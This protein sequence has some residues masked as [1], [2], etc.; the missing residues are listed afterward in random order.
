MSMCNCNCSCPCN[1]GAVIASA[2][3]GIVAAFLQIAGVIT[4]SLIFPVVVLGIAV[5][6]LGILAATSAICPCEE[7]RCRCSALNT[8]LAGILGSVLFSAVL[9]AVGIVATSVLSAILVGLVVFFGT[10]TLTATACYVR[11]QADCGN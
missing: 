4:V 8:V 11:T 7:G 6:Y 9:L 2:I 3:L 1:I 5:V 10:L